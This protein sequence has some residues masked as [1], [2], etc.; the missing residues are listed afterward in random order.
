MELFS[1]S[2]FRPAVSGVPMDF[3]CS[4]LLQRL[5]IFSRIFRRGRCQEPQG[6][7]GR[8]ISGRKVLN[9]LA[10]LPQAKELTSLR[11][12]LDKLL[13]NSIRVTRSSRC[14]YLPS[15]FAAGMDRETASRTVEKIDTEGSGPIC[16]A[17]I[18]LVGYGG[19]PGKASR[20]GGPD[21]CL[22]ERSKTSYTL[23]ESTPAGISP[24]QADCCTQWP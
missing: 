2:F 14:M 15:P 6:I 10:P 19:R 24:A 8:L 9:N 22:Q 13:P 1:T 5:R 3:R 20:N 12:W 4:D 18:P 21:C 16:G 11:R 23:M 7:R 17:G